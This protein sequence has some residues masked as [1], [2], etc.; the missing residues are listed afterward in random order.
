MTLFLFA[1]H[2]VKDETQEDEGVVAIVDFHI[3]HNPL[4][5]LS[6]VAWFWKLALVHKAGPRT[7]GEPT[8]VDPL[9]GH[10]GWESFGEPEPVKNSSKKRQ[11]NWRTT[12][13]AQQMSQQSRPYWGYFHFVRERKFKKNGTTSTHKNNLLCPQYVVLHTKNLPLLCHDSSS[14]CARWMSVF[15]T[16]QISGLAVHVY[17]TVFTLWSSR[18]HLQSVH[19]KD[20]SKN[21]SEGQITEV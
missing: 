5:H 18:Y 20:K 4:T 19:S 14:T 11:L 12:K 2:A 8:P 10:A 1:S 16:E 15:S 3:F 9:F 7:N 17:K 21:F 6:K 13:F